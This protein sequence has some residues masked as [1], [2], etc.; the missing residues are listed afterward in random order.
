MTTEQGY[1]YHTFYRW[2]LFGLLNVS[3]INWCV[4]LVVKI[5]KKKIYRVD[6]ITFKITKITLVAN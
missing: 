4:L 3:K 1:I 5:I 6:D 2:P